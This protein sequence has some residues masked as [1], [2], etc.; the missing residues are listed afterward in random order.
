[1][2]MHDMRKRTGKLF[3]EIYS[4][5]NILIGD[6]LFSH[7][8]AHKCTWVSPDQITVNQIDYIAIIRKHVVPRKRELIYL[9]TIIC[10][11]EVFVLKFV[12]VVVK[13][14]HRKYPYVTLKRLCDQLVN[15]KVTNVAR[16]HLEHKEPNLKCSKS[17]GIWKLI[18]ESLNCF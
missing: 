16:A 18:E 5:N 6:P 11:W 15:P 4:V 7:K 14:V 9:V 13:S 12:L 17:D 10:L 1:M 3:I 8:T 2:S